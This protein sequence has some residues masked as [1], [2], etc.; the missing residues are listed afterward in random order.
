MIQKV[1]SKIYEVALH[2]L[3]T[4]GRIKLTFYEPIMGRV[5]MK[6]MLR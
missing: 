3:S 5:K 6:V 4:F 2:R 1:S